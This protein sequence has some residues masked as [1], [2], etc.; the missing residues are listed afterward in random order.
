M[1]R[2]P[3]AAGEPTT[4]LPAAA[5]QPGCW[6]RAQPS[7]PKFLL[8][9]PLLPS[10]CYSHWSPLT[11]PQTA[12]LHGWPAL[13]QPIAPRLYLGRDRKGPLHAGFPEVTLWQ[14]LPVQIW[15]MYLEERQRKPTPP[16][17]PNGNTPCAPLGQVPTGPA[18]CRSLRDRKSAQVLRGRTHGQQGQAGTHPRAW[19]S[20]PPQ[21]PHASAQERG[22]RRRPVRCSGPRSGGAAEALLSHHCSFI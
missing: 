18:H 12:P 7:Q 1:Q 14:P 13:C 16:T 10:N 3:P 2:S 8:A 21:E 20:A 9:K 17:V 4:S 22:R 15:L 11:Q 5:S 6:S 19:E